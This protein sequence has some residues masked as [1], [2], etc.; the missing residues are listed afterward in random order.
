MAS[1][2]L[3]YNKGLNEKNESYTQYLDFGKL[4]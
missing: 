1:M 4:A 3:S 2:I